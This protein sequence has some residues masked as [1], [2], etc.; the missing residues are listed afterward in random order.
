MSLARRIDAHVH[1]W[2]ISRG[3][4]HWMS[5]DLVALH[6]DFLPQHL[7]QHIKAAGFHEVILVQAAATIAETEFLLSLAKESSFISGV[8]GW[9]NMEADDFK[10]AMERLLIDPK[11]RAIRPMIQD[12]PDPEWMLHDPQREG[13]RV[14]AKLNVCVDLLIKPAHLGAALRLLQ[15]YPDLRAVIDHGAKP[16]IDS[17]EF[18]MW[19]EGIRRLATET[20]AFCKLSG[21][22]TEAGR[23]WSVEKL[24]PYVDCLI[25]F[26]GPERLL[27]GSDWPVLTTASDYSTWHD[28][29]GYLLSG[30]TEPQRRGIYGENAARF[31]GV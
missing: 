4:Y 17:G 29:V 2:K 9:A 20:S 3:D 25:E 12:I 7:I 13:F 16:R 23:D 6:R 11:L 24:R 5:P 1:F 8:V 18:T 27:F 14:L 10:E 31:Y 19:A 30:L 22:I 26:F 15:R 28:T 21:L